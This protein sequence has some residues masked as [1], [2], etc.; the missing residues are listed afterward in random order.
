MNG[1][2][3]DRR[4]LEAIAKQAATAAAGGEFLRVELNHEAG[5]RRL[6]AA[7]RGG[8]LT[9]W[10]ALRLSVT[11]HQMGDSLRGAVAGGQSEEFG[12]LMD[13]VATAEERAKLAAECYERA[14]LLAA[15]A[16]KAAAEGRATLNEWESYIRGN[17]ALERVLARVFEVNFPL[18]FGGKKP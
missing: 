8:P 17:R 3:V 18:F 13:A 14:E 7:V 11:L 5:P 10:Q 12:D 9:P 2:K 1:E 6:K 16:E 15:A 4:G